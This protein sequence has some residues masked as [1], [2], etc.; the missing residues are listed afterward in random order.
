MSELIPFSNG[1]Q[2]LDWQECNC[3]R[4]KKY[5]DWFIEELTCDL[6]KAIED[7]SCGDGTVSEEIYKRLGAGT[8]KYC[9]KCPE[10][11]WDEGS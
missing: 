9:W 2:F 1:T 3:C 4:C 6:Q 10:V 11:D 7:S 8:G 5:K